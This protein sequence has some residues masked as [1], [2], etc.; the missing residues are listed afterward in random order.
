MTRDDHS[1]G[2]LGLP[3]IGDDVT[4]VA[5]D[6]SRTRNDQWRTGHFLGETIGQPVSRPADDR[7]AERDRELTVKGLA[8]A[9]RVLPRS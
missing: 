9:H 2:E 7:Q 8:R 5:A 1:V 3:I 4:F 6:A